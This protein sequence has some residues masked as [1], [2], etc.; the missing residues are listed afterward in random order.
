MIYIVCNEKT[1]YNEIILERSFFKSNLYINYE[2]AIS[3]EKN[4]FLYKE[5]DGEEVEFTLKGN[6]I[7]GMQLYFN[8][9]SVTILK[10]INAF[11]IVLSA[12]PLAL[13]VIGGFNGGIYGE[14]QTALINGIICAVAGMEVMIS[15]CR[16]FENVFTKLLFSIAVCLFVTGLWYFFAILDNML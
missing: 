8:D 4:R 7:L 3:L 1:N 13:A 2:K 11:E 16:K 5:N 15:F 9:C 10:K 12:L 14:L 6:K